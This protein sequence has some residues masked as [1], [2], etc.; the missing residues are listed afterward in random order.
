M[1]Q[2]PREASKQK[3]AQRLKASKKKCFDLTQV[4]ES[5]ENED[6][7]GAAGVGVKVTIQTY[8]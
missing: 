6:K 4:P 5:S 7:S 1:T 8:R 2:G 3:T